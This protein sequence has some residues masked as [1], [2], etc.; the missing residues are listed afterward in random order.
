MSNF[1]D[2]DL[3]STEF[4]VAMRGYDRAQVD[5]Y[6][7]QVL[8]A[9]KTA[10]QH[11]V[12][13][14]RRLD[15]VRTKL[16]RTEE[17]IAG[18]ERRLADSDAAIAEN[19]RPTLAGLGARVEKLLRAA[20]LEADDQR[21]DARRQAADIR[22]RAL[23]EAAETSESARMEAHSVTGAAERDAAETRT[24]AANE[25][26]ELRTNA[27]RA[28]DLKRADATRESEQIRGVAHNEAAE[29]KSSAEREVAMQRAVTDR[30]VTQLRAGVARDVDEQHANA[31]TLLAEAAD[32]RQ[33]EM[34]EL[35]LTLAEKR[36][37]AEREESARHS[38]AVNA[39]THVVEEAEQRA[40]LAEQRS[41]ESE[42]RAQERGIDA[43]RRAADLK[44]RAEATAAQLRVEAQSEAARIRAEAESEALSLVNPLR[45][46][47]D[48][49]TARRDSVT[50]HLG[51]LQRQLGTVASPL[52]DL[53]AEGGSLP[54]N[55]P[56]EPYEADR[57]TQ[58][59]PVVRSG[60]LAPTARAI[61]RAT[62]RTPARRPRP[63]PYP[64]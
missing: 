2:S 57:P 13:A 8:N 1:F 63:R 52:R 34:Q 35:A 6:A 15:D 62:V 40:Y 24:T 44:A 12:D 39:A 3:Q 30:E 14:E 47:L 9:M 33:S 19:E 55:R 7:Q 11:R 25:A 61:G 26:Q 28:H 58:Q 53:L 31:N 4:S 32:K 54:I 60:D 36:E 38:Q 20:E 51:E 37:R 45:E 17:R 41:R 48:N 18:L 49:L 56:R 23:A 27:R 29:L 10:K 21:E 46:E 5:S 64:R 50:A 43:D 59:I 22:A 16:R 42:Q